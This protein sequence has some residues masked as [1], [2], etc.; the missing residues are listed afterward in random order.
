[1]SNELSVEEQALIK[2]VELANL[3]ASF[4][5]VVEA[6]LKSDRDLAVAFDGATTA[7]DRQTIAQQQINVE[8]ISAVVQV[9]MLFGPKED[10]NDALNNLVPASLAYADAVARVASRVMDSEELAGLMPRAARQNGMREKFMS[11]GA[12]NLAKLCKPR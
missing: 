6:K 8:M 1:M 5:E 7:E 9:T 12:A 4:R 3:A 2:Q 11:N 10:L